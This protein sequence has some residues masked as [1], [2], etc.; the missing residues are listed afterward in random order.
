MRGVG[1]KLVELG[2]QAK[3]RTMSRVKKS[4]VRIDE[5]CK[6]KGAWIAYGEVMISI[7][8]GR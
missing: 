1:V 7:I 6:G 2:G 4:A 8:P 5:D 3:S